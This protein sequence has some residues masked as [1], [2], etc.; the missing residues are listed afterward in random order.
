[1][2][3]RS[4]LTL[5]LSSPY[6]LTVS[7]YDVAVFSFQHGCFSFQ[8]G[9]VVS[10]SVQVGATRFVGQKVGNAEMATDQFGSGGGF[11]NMFKQADYQTAAVAKC[12]GAPT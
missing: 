4:L 11:S 12:V 8:R 3:L 5:W 10:H 6:N 9:L 2:C 1:M 7:R